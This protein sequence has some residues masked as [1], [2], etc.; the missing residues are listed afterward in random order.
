MIKTGVIYWQEADLGSLSW[1]ESN[2]SISL[3]E[4]L[5]FISSTH[6]SA[7]LPKRKLELFQRVIENLISSSY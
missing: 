7:C 1:H 6:I 2:E 5:D 4:E 3:L